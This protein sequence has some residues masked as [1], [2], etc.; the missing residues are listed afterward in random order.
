MFTLP[1]SVTTWNF[2]GFA[3]DKEMNFGMIESEAVASKKV[4]VILVLQLR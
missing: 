4:M 3:H 2:R 1:E